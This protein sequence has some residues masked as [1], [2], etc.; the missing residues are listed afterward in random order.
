MSIGDKNLYRCQKCGKSIVTIDLDEGVTPFMIECR[1]TLGCDG[2]MYSSLYK[3][4]PLQKAIPPSYE[5]FK[6]TSF[7]HYSE[8]GRERMKEWVAQGCLDIRKINREVNKCQ[9]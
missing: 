5:W 6:P 9:Q 3:L 4:N 1:A 7:D 2:D 8:E